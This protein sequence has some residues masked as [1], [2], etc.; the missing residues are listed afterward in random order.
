[1]GRFRDNIIGIGRH[2][3]ARRRTHCILSLPTTSEILFMLLLKILLVEKT[4]CD[5]I[6]PQ[7]VPFMLL[8]LLFFATSV[9]AT[10]FGLSHVTSVVHFMLLPRPF[11][12]HILPTSIVY[13]NTILFLLLLRL[14][15]QNMAAICTS[16]CHLLEPT[17]H[18][19][20]E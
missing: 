16:S 12:F 1:M 15:A 19:V 18:R 14:V 5:I 3:H 20:T 4:R 2:K 13:Y 17:R 6:V 7:S 9:F 8:Y 10:L 11:L